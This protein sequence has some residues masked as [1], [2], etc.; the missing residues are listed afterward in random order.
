MLG[1]LMVFVDGC[2]VRRTVACSHVPISSEQEELH[3]PE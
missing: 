2:F 1:L 3:V